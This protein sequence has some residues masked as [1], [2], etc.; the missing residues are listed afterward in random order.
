MFGIVER[1]SEDVDLLAEFP[2]EA[3]LN[4]RHEILKAFD[5]AVRKHLSLENDRVIVGSSRTGV[6][7]YTTYATPTAN[8]DPSSKKGVLLEKKGVLLELGSRDGTPPS[9]SHSYRSFVADH[10]ITVLGEEKSV[11][12]EFVPL[13]VDVLAP[14]RTL[15][16]KLAESAWLS[17]LSEALSSRCRLG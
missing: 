6:K 3:S 13:D 12:E 10:A 4:A 1:L 9:A 11:W 7:R 2:V 15:F 8:A 17:F 16:E 14:E 5:T